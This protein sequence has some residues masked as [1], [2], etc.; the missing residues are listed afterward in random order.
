MAK[1]TDYFHQEA[2]PQKKKKYNRSKEQSFMK[3]LRNLHGNIEEI[4]KISNLL[5]R[6]E[7]N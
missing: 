3:D 6:Y 1:N 2:V 4:T 7:K 5:N